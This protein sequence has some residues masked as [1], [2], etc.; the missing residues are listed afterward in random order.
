MITLEGGTKQKECHRY[1]ESLLKNLSTVNALVLLIYT[2]SLVVYISRPSMQLVSG[3]VSP[4]QRRDALF[5]WVNYVDTSL[6]F[7]LIYLVLLYGTYG[8]SSKF[9]TFILFSTLILLLAS[10]IALGVIC[11]IYISQANSINGSVFN[12]AHSP[13]FCCYMGPLLVPECASKI[14]SSYCSTDPLAS[15]NPNVIPLRVNPVFVE[16]SVWTLVYILFHGAILLLQYQIHKVRLIVRRTGKKMI[17][18]TSEE[19]TPALMSVGGRVISS[20]SS[21]KPSPPPPL[22]PTHP[23]ST[24]EDIGSVD[25]L[26]KNLCLGITE[27]LTRTNKTMSRYL[28]QN[29]NK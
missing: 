18:N 15:I 20:S 11:L 9:A 21:L 12:P 16:Y 2:A 13:Q 5:S 7:L 8:L 22:Q 3:T 25:F 19:N 27:K 1:N 10:G 24:L 14:S 23:P 6:R 29:K 28:R 26:I 17:I 4:L